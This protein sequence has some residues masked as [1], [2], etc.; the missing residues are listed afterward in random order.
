MNK[1][2]NHHYSQTLN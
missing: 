2:K 1:C